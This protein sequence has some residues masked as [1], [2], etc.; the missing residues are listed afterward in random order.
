MLTDGML[1]DIAIKAHGDM[2]A[3]LNEQG[4][5]NTRNI[6]TRMAVFQ[7]R[8]EMFLSSSIKKLNHRFIFTFP[9]SQVSAAL[10]R[11]AVTSTNPGLEATEEGMKNGLFHK[12][13][14]ACGEPAAIHLFARQFQWNHKDGIDKSRIMAIGVRGEEIVVYPPCS[15]HGP[16]WGCARLL[17]ELKIRA[18]DERIVRESVP[19]DWVV[20]A[21]VT[22]LTG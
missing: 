12:Y 17:A 16:Q 3:T 19:D 18:I 4:I 15:G 1:I 8:G 11:C 22:C 7:A 21:E 2:V 5:T 13:G 6:P 10:A 20:R 14:A 9:L